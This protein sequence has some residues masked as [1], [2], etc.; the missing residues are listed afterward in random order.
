LAEVRV[1]ARAPTSPSQRGAA[2]TAARRAAAC[3]P[4]TPRLVAV[5]AHAGR[6]P[7]DGL[8]VAG[9]P[10]QG[11]WVAMLLRVMDG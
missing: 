4:A 9:V 5:P 11:V 7:A 2:L 10:H 8:L 3:S 6:A 1:H